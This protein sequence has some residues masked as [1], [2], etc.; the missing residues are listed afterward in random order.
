MKYNKIMSII[1][2]GLML[3][4]LTGCGTSASNNSGNTASTE[5]SDT[6]EPGDGNKQGGRNGGPQQGGGNRGGGGN[7][8]KSGDE[9]LQSIISEVVSKYQVLEYQD[10]ETGKTLTYNL[11]VP[12][13]YDSSK[14]YPLVLF[15]PDASLPGKGAEAA[16]TQGYGGIIWATAENQAK[17]ECFVVVPA[18]SE[19]IVNDNFEATDEADMTI[20]LLQS[21]MNDY[22]ID[23]N[24]LYTTGQSMGCMTSMYL[25]LKYP[26]FFAASLYVGG[27]W[28]TSKMGV[29]AD[30]NFFYIVAEGDTKASVGMND[31]KTV[32]ESEGAPFSQAMWDA[33]WPQEQFTEATKELVSEGNSVNMV[34]FNKGTVMPEGV[35]ANNEHMY[36][37]DYAYKIDAVRDWLFQQSK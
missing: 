36:S 31:L 2:G 9:Q 14:S 11:F 4:S 6:Q 37:F 7:I 3:F 22:S 10:A 8:D 17:N 23:N 26:D 15:M 13:N 19:T 5:Q 29:L 28:D 12:E 35:E 30:T 18:Y 21:V 20:R 25:N 34:M 32:F 33:T 27:Q 24:R 1:L 16:L